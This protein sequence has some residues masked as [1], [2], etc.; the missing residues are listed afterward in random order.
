MC[1]LPSKSFKLALPHRTRQIGLFG[2]GG[3]PGDSDGKESTGNVEEQGS[4]P[5][6][7][8]SPG[9]G[10]DYP[11]QYSCLEISMDRGVLWATVQWGCKELDTT[12]QHFHTMTV[13]KLKKTDYTKHR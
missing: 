2:K 5:D 12:E 10:N 9:E 8:K 11:L 6:L 1:S 4:I 7:G 3:F 13:L